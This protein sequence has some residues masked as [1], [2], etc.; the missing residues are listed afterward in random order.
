MD[1]ALQDFIDLSDQYGVIIDAGGRVLHCNPALFSVLKCTPDCIEDVFA[2]RAETVLPVIHAAL[3][4]GDKTSAELETDF[5]NGIR[6]VFCQIYPVTLSGATVCVVLF[7]PVDTLHSL[8]RV[9]FDRRAKFFSDSRWVVDENF[10]VLKF[11]AHQD[12]IFY[13]RQPGFTLFEAIM[14]RDHEA[15]QSAFNKAALAPGEMITVTVDAYRKHGISRVE[16]DIYYAPDLFYGNRYFVWSR[17]AINRT[18]SILDRLV[19]AYQV[20]RDQDLAEKLNVKP[21]AISNVRHG[22]RPLPPLWLQL[23]Y[24]DCKVN[25]HWLYSGTG[26]KFLDDV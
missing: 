22:R 25:Y 21:S 3:E 10:K 6:V 14:E 18:L 2:D 4:S 7:H 1:R 12:S 8:E 9:L 24:L 11:H 20:T 16:I 15:M 26:K 5:G 19:E 17:P 13:G 23:C